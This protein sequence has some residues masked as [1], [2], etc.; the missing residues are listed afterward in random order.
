VLRELVTNALYH[1][2]A[3]RIEV[4]MVLLGPLLSLQVADD[5]LGRDPA[6]WAHGLGLGGVRKRVKLLG[7]EVAWRENA[8]CGI[9]C[10]VRIPEFAV[11]S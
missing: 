10:A 7:G 11:G 2:H 1:G 6:G 3:T 5:G 8:P 4:V 9:V